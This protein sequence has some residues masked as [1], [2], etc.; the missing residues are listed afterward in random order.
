MLD[1]SCA[2]SQLLPERPELPFQGPVQGNRGRDPAIDRYIEAACK[3]REVR[4]YLAL[5]AFWG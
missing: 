3:D 4:A 5:P 1:P 2:G